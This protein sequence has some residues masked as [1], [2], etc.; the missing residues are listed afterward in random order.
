MVHISSEKIIAEVL[1][2]SE[3]FL[4]CPLIIDYTVHLFGLVG[5]MPNLIPLVIKI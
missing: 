3:F 1:V 5:K 4:F 2:C